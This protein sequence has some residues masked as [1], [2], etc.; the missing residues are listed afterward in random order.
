VYEITYNQ[1]NVL[2]KL[3]AC[4][5]GIKWELLDDLCPKEQVSK[6]CLRGLVSIGE[7]TT[8]RITD[9]GKAA[10]EEFPKD[11]A[12]KSKRRVRYRD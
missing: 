6:L 4:G 2:S 10:F 7:C 1:F 11:V 8:V 3:S 9:A 5:D 12:E